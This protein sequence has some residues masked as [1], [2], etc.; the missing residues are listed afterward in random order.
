MPWSPMDLI[1]KAAD[2][3]ST[4]IDVV[5]GEA[6]D[7]KAVDRSMSAKRD[8]KTKKMTQGQDWDN[9]PRNAL[10]HAYWSG[11]MAQELGP[12][13]ASAIGWANEGLGILNDAIDGKPHDW[14]DMKLDL[15][16]NRIGVRAGEVMPD[17]QSLIA[18]IRNRLPSTPDSP[19]AIPGAFSGSGNK[20]MYI[21]PVQRGV[22]S[23][24]PTAEEIF[25][26]ILAAPSDQ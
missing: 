7:I 18:V 23:P 13:A 19:S 11:R 1:R 12:T 15:N 5:M 14:D 26:A 17:K 6:P 25:R 16:N 2:K 9:T 24:T 8:D 21:K 20:L 10:R 22:D 3:A 4:V